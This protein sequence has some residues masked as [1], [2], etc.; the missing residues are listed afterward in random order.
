MG[1]VAVA[2]DDGR[3]YPQQDVHVFGHDDKCI[4]TNHAIV[5]ADA[6]KQFFLHHIPYWG[7]GHMRSVR[8]AVRLFERALNLSQ[9]LT[10]SFCHMQGDVVDAGQRVIVGSHA[11]LHAVADRVLPVHLF[12]FKPAGEPPG[13]LF[14][15]CRRGNRRALCSVIAGGGAAG[16]SVL[17][18][19]AGEPPGATT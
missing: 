3:R 6:G 9:G 10:H 2:A 14:C 1:G 17:S 18:L 4:D 13:T 12:S 11:A 8:A 7:Q 16:H 19:P 5:L 15:H